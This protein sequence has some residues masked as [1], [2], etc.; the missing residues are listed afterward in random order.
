MQS[1]FKLYDCY[2]HADY[3]GEDVSIVDHSRMAAE[4]ASRET[5]DPIVVAA[6]FLHDI[7]HLVGFML[8]LPQMDSLGTCDH[9][10]IGARYLR[11]AGFPQRLCDLVEHHVDAK[12]YLVAREPDYFN[13]L[14]DASQATLSHEGGAMS[15]RECREFEQHPDSRWFIRFRQWEEQAKVLRDS[16]TFDEWKAWIGERVALV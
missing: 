2:G 4:V 5:D 12:R 1:V 10:R 13:K 9:D 16:K 3:I 8:E 11:F 14:S 6:A 15:E 7:G